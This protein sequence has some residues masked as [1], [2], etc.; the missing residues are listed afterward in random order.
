MYRFISE[1]NNVAKFEVK[2]NEKI[3]ILNMYEDG[4]LSS[5]FISFPSLL[6]SSKMILTVYNIH[7]YKFDH[8]QDYYLIFRPYINRSISID[9]FWDSTWCPSYIYVS[10]RTLRNDTMKYFLNRDSTT[11]VNQYQ[12]ELENSFKNLSLDFDI[13]INQ[14]IMNKDSSKQEIEN[15]I[16]YSKKEKSKDI[17]EKTNL[18]NNQTNE[19]DED[20][21]DYNNYNHANEFDECYI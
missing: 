3:V 4:I 16:L 19:F 1:E 15:F 18:F 14:D 11:K 6:F 2:N 17:S 5:D 7:N 21:D 9:I 8:K 12:I 20:M 10:P 13:D